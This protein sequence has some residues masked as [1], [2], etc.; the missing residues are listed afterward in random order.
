MEEISGHGVRA[1]V[2]GVKVAVG[3]LRLMEQE[4]TLPAE[5]EYPVGT[6][7]HLS[8]D[9]VYG[10]Y[11]VISDQLKSDA[12][13]A[14]RGLK[15]SGVKKIVMLTGDL[16]AVGDA[17]GRELQ[18]DEVRAELLPGDKVDEVERLLSEKSEKGKLVFVG[19]GINDAP[20]LSRAD[21]GIAMGGLGSD[22]AIE[23]ADIVIMDDKPSKIA[24]AIA[25][26]RKTLRIVHQNIV[27][28]LGIKAL[29]MIL[30]LFNIATMWMGVF[31]DVGVAF[32]AILNA[33]RALHVDKK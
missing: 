14:V 17:I 30:A 7:V 21:I 13:E 11:V 9:G 15:A 5:Q 3:N 19:D 24:D 23:A 20:V 27:F 32:I 28:A 31:A 18:V 4:N 12:K 33:M 8:A 26:S 6:I 25:I 22:A 16:Q 2:D 1:V 29:V 10:G